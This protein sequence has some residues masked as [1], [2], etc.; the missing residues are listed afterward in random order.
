MTALAFSPAF[1]PAATTG[2]RRIALGAAAIALAI[3]FNVPFS[4]LGATFD[5]PNVL[6]RPAGE[7]LDQFAAGSAP[8]ILTWYAFMACAL[9]LAVIAPLI[10][11]TRARL[12]AHPATAIAA[13]SLGAL[14]GLAQAIGLSRWVFAI[15]GLANLH[16]DPAAT[17]EAKLFAERSYALMG[18]LAGVGVG[19]HI[20]QLLTAAFIACV[21]RLQWQEKTHVSAILALLTTIT[22]MIGAAEG[23]ALSLGLSGETF[24]M[25]TIIGFSGLTLWLI[26]SGVALVRGR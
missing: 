9:A 24:A 3:A 11:V 7:V 19:E 5:Y 21:G 4:I 18:A 20:G 1:A 12:A 13:A 14:A 10:S 16:A 23:P 26:A 22:L 17:A 6:R 15:P 25:A 2:N 8:L